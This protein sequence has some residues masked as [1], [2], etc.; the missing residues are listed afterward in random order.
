[1]KKNWQL[2][3][4]LPAKLNKIS[5]REKAQLKDEEETKEVQKRKVP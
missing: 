3:E 2:T 1:M 4:S 5:Q